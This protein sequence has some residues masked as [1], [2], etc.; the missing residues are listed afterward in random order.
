[1]EICR[2]SAI[3]SWL[4]LHRILLDRGFLLR[5]ERPRR[6]IFGLRLWPTST[7]RRVAAIITLTTAFWLI[8]VILEVVANAPS[9]LE[10]LAT[11]SHAPILPSLVLLLW[12]LLSAAG[13]RLWSGSRLRGLYDWTSALQGHPMLL[14]AFK[15]LVILMVGVPAFALLATSAANQGDMLHGILSLA[16]L[17]LFLSDTVLRNPYA[18]HAPHRHGPDALRIILPTTHHEGTVYVLPDLDSNSENRGFDAVWSPKIPDE[19]R[20]ADGEIMALFQR[21]RSN[22]WARSEPL[23]RLRETLAQ[24]YKRVSV[25]GLAT[26]HVERLARWIYAA[27]TTTTTG[28]SN[29][30]VNDNDKT[31]RKI[32][33]L[34]A[35]GTHLI[36]RDLMFALCHAEYIVFMAQGQLSPETR[37]KLGTLRLM[38]RSGAAMQSTSD[39]VEAIGYAN[40]GYVGYRDAVEHVYAIFGYSP[41]EIDR[42][43][44]EF[45]GVQPPRFSYALDG[46][47]DTIEE[48]VGELWDLA[49]RHSES[50]F[51][52][53]W[54]FTTVWFMEIGNVNGFYIFPF[55][56]QS[57]DGDQ[58]SQHIVLRQLLWAGCVSQLVSV[59]PVLFGAF[60][61]GFMSR[62]P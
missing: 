55:R 50:T 25:D 21:M 40:T 28:H 36:G 3:V 15:S 38:T 52:A 19:H 37:S 53:L 46:S 6:G 54:F 12:Y 61:A 2:L 23:E 10:A 24:F 59:S 20:A 30:K 22:R 13:P 48:Y 7:D 18:H 41:S 43:A 11:L 16:G 49:C 29:E 60:V 31:S 9:I 45:R 56:C 34:R 17:F 35:P 33:C 8:A 14:Y 32:E 1:M 51:S 42:S 27:P 58:V 62:T 26:E 57:R 44:L 5:H 47:P 39:K 4:L